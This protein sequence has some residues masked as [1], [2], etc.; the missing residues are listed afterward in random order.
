MEDIKVAKSHIEDSG[1][2][3]EWRAGGPSILDV[4][5]SSSSVHMNRNG[6]TNHVDTQE[7]GYPMTPSRVQER[8]FRFGDLYHPRKQHKENREGITS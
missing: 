2:T 1:P 6:A 7:N 4:P 8:H 5:K 3:Q